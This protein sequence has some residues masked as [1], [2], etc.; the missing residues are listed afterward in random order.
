MPKKISKRE[1]VKRTPVNRKRAGGKKRKTPI[2][3][4]ESART[5]APKPSALGTV[6]HY[7][8]GIRV[9]IV[10]FREPVRAGTRVRFSGHTTAFTQT[11]TSFEYDHKKIAR[12]PK[13]KQVGVKVAKRVREGDA[14]FFIA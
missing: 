1:P 4:S 8:N 14:L 13:G 11:L 5:R 10:R 3:A 6:T 7:Y 9:A 12:A 2:R